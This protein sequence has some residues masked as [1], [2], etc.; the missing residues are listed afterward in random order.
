MDNTYLSNI[1]DNFTNSLTI[2]KVKS[3]HMYAFKTKPVTNSSNKLHSLEYEFFDISMKKK[4][5][6][7]AVDRILGIFNKKYLEKE[8]TVFQEYKIDN[9]KTV[10]D[11]IDLVDIDF[12]SYDEENINSDNYKIQYFLHQLDLNCQTAYSKKDYIKF[13][14]SALEV[15]TEDNNKMLII[16]KTAPIYKPKG[17]LYIFN[18]KDIEDDEDNTFELIDKKLFRLPLYPHIIITDNKCLLIE[19]DVESIFGFEKYNRKRRDDILKEI[20][21]NLP[22]EKESFHLIN[23]FSNKGRNYNLFSTFD[24]QRY[25]NIIKKD[26]E[27][28]DFLKSTLQIKFDENNNILITNES[29]SEKLISYLCNCLYMDLENEDLVQATNTKKL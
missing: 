1:I 8:T 23:S 4:D 25:N 5:V 11:Y 10:I 22:I 20:E 21:K 24:D 2:D 26:P 12:N 16:N 19:N 29:E 6:L 18:P 3:A 7:V 14:H 15:T 27:T 13:K 17:L 9:P 28:I